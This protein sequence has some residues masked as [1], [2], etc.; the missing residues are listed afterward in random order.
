LKV[1]KEKAAE[2]RA[3]LVQAAGR[4]FRERGIDGVGVADVCK[5]AGLTH[6]ALYAQF[7][8]KEA[9]A[10][11][12][13]SNAFEHGFS[14]MTAA[15]EP[16]LTTYLDYLISIRQRDNLGGGCPLTASTSEV[17]RKD[18]NISSR[19]AQGFEKMVGAV[20]AVLDPSSPRSDRRDR[21][22]TIVATNIG[23]IA[24]ARATAKSRPDLSNDILVAARRILAEVGGGQSPASKTRRGQPK[25]RHP[26]KI[27]PQRR[28]VASNR[29]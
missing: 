8:S 29:T 9:L 22:L 26:R 25:G 23:A 4:L 18:E 17:G 3:K 5:A 15:T 28:R 13:F 14:R 27:A 6:G 10:A 20:E 21:A 12:A 11:A 2:N 16:S 24:V 1:T 19:F 7:P